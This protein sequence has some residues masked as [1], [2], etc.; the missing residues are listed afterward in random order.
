[1][2]GPAR[3]CW[4]ASPVCRYRAPLAG[5]GG[6]AGRGGERNLAVSRYR[7]ALMEEPWDGVL[8]L[9]MGSTAAQIILLRPGP[10]TVG[11]SYIDI[12]ISA[13]SSSDQIPCYFHRC[14]RDRD[15]I[16]PRVDKVR[17]VHDYCHNPHHQTRQILGRLPTGCLFR[18]FWL[19]SFFSSFLFSSLFSSFL[20][21]FVFRSTLSGG[22]NSECFL[23]N[24]AGVNH[25][26]IFPGTFLF[27]RLTPQSIPRHLARHL[28]C[29]LDLPDHP[30]H[31]ASCLP[32][33]LSA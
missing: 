28:L 23:L 22:V 10:Y 2:S 18:Y 15:R 16:V 33:P 24:A 31:S 19:R 1:M 13:P 14:N 5:C 25:W 32:S 30:R 3:M 8:I 12:G 6:G 4:K 17:E 27:A 7:S 20:F 29:M 9:W 26:R 11:N 21:S